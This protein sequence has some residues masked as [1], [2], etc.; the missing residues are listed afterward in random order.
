MHNYHQQ[1]H[2]SQHAYPHNKLISFKIYFK[3]W[4]GI[5]L[6]AI[7]YDYS[8]KHLS[9]SVVS[10]FPLDFFSQDKKLLLSAI[11]IHTL[12]VVSFFALSRLIQQDYYLSLILSLPLYFPCTL[13]CSSAYFFIIISLSSLFTC[14]Q[15]LMTVSSHLKMMI[16]MMMMIMT[17]IV[18]WIL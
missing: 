11:I 6:F 5:V 12:S 2:L 9:W 17:M 16:T 3:S 8:H 7:C 13:H 14:L 18:L 1:S 10:W 15:A 4:L